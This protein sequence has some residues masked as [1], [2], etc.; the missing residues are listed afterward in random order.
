MTMVGVGRDIKLNVAVHGTGK[1]NVVFIHGNLGCAAWFDL[2]YP[3][4]PPLFTVYCIEWKGCGDSDKP[5]PKSDY[6]NYALE[7]HA[8]EMILAINSLAISKCHIAAHSTGYFIAAYMLLA[9]PDR[10]DKVLALDPVG[11]GSLPFDE[12]GLQFFY[13]ARND[14]IIARSGMASA[15]STLFRNGTISAGN[16]VFSAHTSKDQRNTFEL[17]VTKALFAGD[18]IW[19]GTPINLDR[20]YRR[21]GLIDKQSKLYHPHLVLWGEHDPIIPKA[22]VQ[23]MVTEMPNCQVRP[24]PK[25]GH[26]MN[27]ESPQLYAEFFSSFLSD[28]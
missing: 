18:G 11:P 16:P 17:L 6:S 13:K 14:R 21:G 12:A 25:V 19:L 5:S 24:C 10:F 9:E 7:V 15:A 22:T 23:R 26:S 8:H 27:I 28:Q 3:L 20:E 4:L 1:V 2:V